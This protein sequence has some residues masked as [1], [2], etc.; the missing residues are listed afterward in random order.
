MSKSV[1]NA[2]LYNG[3]LVAVP[4]HQVG[5]YIRNPNSTQNVV[6]LT[7]PNES[8]FPPQNLDIASD[9]E[10]STYNEYGYSKQVRRLGVSS[11][12]PDSVLEFVKPTRIV[13]NYLVNVLVQRGGLYY[14][15][16]DELDMQVASNSLIYQLLVNPDP[17]RTL[18]NGGL[19]YP[20]IIR[21]NV[22]AMQTLLAN[23][24]DDTFTSKWARQP[25]FIYRSDGGNEVRIGNTDFLLHLVNTPDGSW[26]LVDD[27]MD[28]TDNEMFQY[29][30]DILF[31]AD[32]HVENSP[33]ALTLNKVNVMLA[34]PAYDP[35]AGATRE[36]AVTLPPETA[37]TITVGTTDYTFTDMS[38]F[39]ANAATRLPVD[40]IG[41]LFSKEVP[42]EFSCD[43]ATNTVV[44]TGLSEWIGPTL[45]ER[46]YIT[47]T[48]GDQSELNDSGQDLVPFINTRFGSVVTASEPADTV[49]TIEI[50]SINDS[51]VHVSIVRDTSQWIS[52]V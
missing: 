26:W 52:I 14:P 17:L 28:H 6:E 33:N 23:I 30:M 32:G 36:A 18:N 1:L 10:D 42:T 45:N 19:Y 47:I 24:N 46:Y 29:T 11:L 2:I 27:S 49:D 50:R 40:V 38:D 48:I 41:T 8:G 5:I 15:T 35:C 4:D 13:Y 12:G 20:V 21:I 31:N 39:A 7:T 3:T 37:F 9:Y 16:Y 51:T 25:F 34:T 22:A 43:G 44:L